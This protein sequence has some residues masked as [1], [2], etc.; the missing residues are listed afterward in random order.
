MGFFSKIRDG[1]KKTREN[2]SNQISQMLHS[3]TKIDDDL[4]EELEELLI[5]GDVGMNS[6]EHICES[7]KK[8]GN[9]N[10]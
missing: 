6:A 10:R 3:F 2:I 5:M 8:K 9:G 7:V 4:F 1:L